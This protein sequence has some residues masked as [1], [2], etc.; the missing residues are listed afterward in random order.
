MYL[1]IYI[2]LCVVSIY[3]YMCM[4]IG[5]F[6]G[7]MMLGASLREDDSEDGSRGD[8]LQMLP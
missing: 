1:Y 2:C 5:I 8:V 7:N 4:R 6:W 3:I